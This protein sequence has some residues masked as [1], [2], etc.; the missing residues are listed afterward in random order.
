MSSQLEGRRIAALVEDGFEE[1]EFTGPAEA[2]RNAGARVDIV[3]P[4]E[5]TV[6]S[7]SHGN[8]GREY[9]VDVPLLSA[10]PNAYDALLIP[11]GV[12]SPDRMRRNPTAWRL[13]QAFFTAEKPVAVICHG[14]WML[15]DSGVIDGRRLT[16]YP[17]LQMDLRNADADWVDQEVVVDRGLI[18]SR[19]PEDIPAFNKAFIEQLERS[20]QRRVAAGR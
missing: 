13:I 3:S 1:V 4:R 8:W 12:R 15:I 17:S 20:P 5:D 16:S 10:D 18:T 2:L 9:Q 19:R 11:G 6:K 14:P 7:W